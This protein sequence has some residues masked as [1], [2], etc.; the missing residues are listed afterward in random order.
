MVTPVGFCANPDTA[1]TNPHQAENPEDLS[2]IRQQAVAEHR[3]F[4]ELLTSNG[5]QVT[6]FEGNPNHSDDVFCNNWFSTH[7]DGSFCLY[8]MMAKSRR[9]ERR[10]DIIDYMTKHYQ[11]KMDLSPSENI[12]QFLESTG[13]LVLDRVHRQVFAALSPRTNENL[14]QQWCHN[15][16]YTPCLFESTDKCGSLEYHTNV[17]LFV[18]SSIAGFCPQNIRDDQQRQNLRSALSKHHALL[19]LS[20]DQVNNFAANALEVRN[21]QGQRILIISQRGWN[22]LTS[23]QKDLIH[24]HVDQVLTPSIPTLETYGGGSAR[25]CLGELF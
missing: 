3:H 19:E 10:S 23:P 11:L 25:C 22:S 20:P 7:Q 17:I 21:S 14:I 2:T 12:G 15:M 24:Q 18:G 13:S 5:V 9:L 1:A 16:G 8:P 6:V 4:R